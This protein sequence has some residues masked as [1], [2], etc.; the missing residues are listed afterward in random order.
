MMPTDNIL[1]IEFLP[2]LRVWKP[3]HPEDY[4]TFNNLCSIAW[5]RRR[6][7]VMEH[8]VDE[9]LR[10]AS[11]IGLWLGYEDPRDH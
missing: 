10:A 9:L 4:P 7:Y 6:C 8:E 1:N 11:I 5:G 3:K 2:Y